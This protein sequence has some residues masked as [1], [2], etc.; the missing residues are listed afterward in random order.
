VR[1][2]RETRDYSYRLP[3]SI[4]KNAKR[5]DEALASIKICDP[6]VGSGAFPVGMMHEIVK[7]REVLTPHIADEHGRGDSRIAPTTDPERT[8][9]NFKRHCIQESIYGVDIDPSAV[10][11]AK[12]RLWLSLVVDEE[13][14]KRIKPLPNLEYKIVCGNSLLGVEKDLLNHK[15]FQ[16]LETL[17]PQFFEETNPTRKK[18]LKDKIDSLIKQIT[19]NDEHFDFEVYFSEVFHEKAC[20]ERSRRGGF[21]VVIANPPYVRQEQIKRLKPLLQKH[22]YQIYDSISDLYTYFFEKGYNILKAFGTSTFITSN[23]WMRARYGEK[24]RKFFKEKTKVNQ[25]IDFNG[26]K[27]FE[28]TVDTNITIFQKQVSTN[29]S[30]NFCLIKDDYS[31]KEW[32][33]AGYIKNHALQIPQRTLDYKHFTFADNTV[34]KLKEKI[35]RRG[36]PLAN[37]DVNIN[38]GIVTGLNEAFVINTLTKERICTED[39]KSAEIIKPLLR[40]RDIHK[41]SYKWAGLWLI[42]SRRGIN[43]DKYPRI[44]A[45]LH[46][47]KDKLEPKPPDWNESRDGEW[48]GRKPG[49]YKWYEIQDNIAYYTEFE[50]EKIV[51]PN[52]TKYLPFIYDDQKYFTNQKCYILTAKSDNSFLKYLVAFLNSSV[53][54]WLI[55]TTF[56]ELQGG[57]RELNENIFIN[58]PVPQIDGSNQ[59]QFIALV[60]RILSISKD[61]DYFRSP[62]KQAK[63]KEYERQIDQMVYEL[64]KL[65][66]DEIAIVEGKE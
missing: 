6:T 42:F 62:E 5:I 21:D 12:L 65:T 23:K 38:R 66:D 1:E 9:Y 51:Y 30:I 22:G 16:E 15:L 60:D 2:G 45:Y 25:I 26:Y 64:Y 18:A 35:E 63:V 47:Y 27:V 43:I 31:L 17:K 3:E 41:Y 44:K 49:P 40:G 59:Q 56:P 50:K 46:Q 34:F 29:H 11:I 57:T 14:Y 13:D 53:S 39:P 61:D 52:M 19:N 10:D 48:K 32:S 33:I 20:P 36:V 37:W 28:A 58:F 4:R 54:S 7:A 24:L 8:P 55:R